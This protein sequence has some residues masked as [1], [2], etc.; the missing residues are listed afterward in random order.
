MVYEYKN[1]A[2][3]DA[4]GAGAGASGCGGGGGGLLSCNTQSN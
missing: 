4:V 2:D 3:D 1:G